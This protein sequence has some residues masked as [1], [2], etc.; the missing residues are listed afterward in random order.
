MVFSHFASLT[1]YTTDWMFTLAD[2]QR[3]PLP[4]RWLVMQLRIQNLMGLWC[5]IMQLTEQKLWRPSMLWR[6]SQPI[7]H[8]IHFFFNLYSKVVL[9]YFLFHVNMIFIERS[10]G[11]PLVHLSSMPKISYLGEWSVYIFWFWDNILCF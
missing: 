4:S 7:L 3:K 11:S 1:K 10:R 9:F 2:A 5:L 8:L 6:G